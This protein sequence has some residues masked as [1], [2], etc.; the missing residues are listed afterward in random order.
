MSVKIITKTI[1]KPRDRILDL[2]ETLTISVERQDGYAPSA[3]EIYTAFQIA[4]D[5][6]N[7]K[8]PS[9]KAGSAY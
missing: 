7:K 8:K 3:G 9:T 2:P 6:M 5:G 1:G 4:L